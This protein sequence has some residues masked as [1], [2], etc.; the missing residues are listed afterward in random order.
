MYLLFLLIV[1]HQ[2]ATAEIFYHINLIPLDDYGLLNLKN[3]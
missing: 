3:R 2:K 1:H